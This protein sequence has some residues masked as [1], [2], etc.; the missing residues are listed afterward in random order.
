MASTITMVSP[1]SICP[2][3]RHITMAL[4][5]PWWVHAVFVHHSCISPWH[6]YHH[7]ESVQ[8]L[9]ITQAYHHGI[10]I[11][12]VSPCSICPSLMHITMA[13]LSPWWV[14]AVF[15]HHSGISPWHY[16]HHGES[17]QYLSIT[18]AL[19]W[20]V[21][22]SEDHPIRGTYQMTVTSGFIRTCA[23]KQALPQRCLRWWTGTKTRPPSRLA[24]RN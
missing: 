15:V 19:V 17:V 10:T 7:G 20:G 18:Q 12:M 6:Y 13:F 5:S 14:R 8:C 22:T 9:S 1:C 16:Y 4:L 3:L 11:T 21:H 2:S 23:S 24:V